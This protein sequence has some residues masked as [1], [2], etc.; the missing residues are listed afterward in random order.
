MYSDDE[1]PMT[2]AQISAKVTAL[3]GLGENNIKDGEANPIAKTVSRRL[4][5]METLGNLYSSG[6]QSAYGEAFTE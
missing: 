3:T 2:V 6:N 1:N 5:E 4:Q